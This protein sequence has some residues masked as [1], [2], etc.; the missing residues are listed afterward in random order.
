MVLA[1]RSGQLTAPGARPRARCCLGIIITAVGQ[2]PNYA[3]QYRGLKLYLIDAGYPL[4]Q[5][6]IGGAILA[7]WQ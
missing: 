7:Y 4:L 1:G 5:M 2:V 6:A 3:F